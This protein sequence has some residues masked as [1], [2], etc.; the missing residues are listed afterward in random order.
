MLP[1]AL[2][3]FLDPGATRTLALPLLPYPALF[4][5]FGSATSRDP[6][7][8]S[9]APGALAFGPGDPQTATLTITAGAAPGVTVVDVR[10]GDLHRAIEV[11]VGT[12]AGIRIPDTPAPTVGVEV[13]P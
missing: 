11:V 3:V 7:R 12:P 5:A 13:Q 6:S 1:P 2:Q 8:A 4:P 10:L 9:V